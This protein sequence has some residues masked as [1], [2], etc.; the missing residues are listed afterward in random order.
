MT[1]LW[2]LKYAVDLALQ[3]RRVIE[4]PGR[5]VGAAMA[6]EAATIDISRGVQRFRLRFYH[7]V[8]A[9]FNRE[10][11]GSAHRYGFGEFTLRALRTTLCN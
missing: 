9:H 8:Q 3:K 1:F 5:E 2:W 4:S 10:Y 7:S 6:A 11:L